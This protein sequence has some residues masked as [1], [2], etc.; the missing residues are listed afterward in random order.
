MTATESI[1]INGWPL[2]DGDYVIGDPDSPVAVVTLA[3]DYKKLDRIFDPCARDQ[4]Q[5]VGTHVSDHKNL[6]L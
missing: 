6:S 5:A 1:D 2:T 4:Y 3:S